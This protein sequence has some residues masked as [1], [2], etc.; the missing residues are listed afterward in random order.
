MRFWKNGL[1]ILTFIFAFG[2]SG[3]SK[4]SK[5]ERH[6]SRAEKYFSENKFKEAIIEYKNVL[7][8]EP[9]DA[10]ARHRLGMAY[11]RVGQLREAFSEFVKAVDSDPENAEA[12]IQLGNLY[13]LS[14]DN[15]KA[16]EQ[17]EKVLSRQPN[18]PA[19]R[20]LMSSVF[21]AE[22]NLSGAVSEAQKAIELDP[23][24]IDSHL[25]LANLCI[26][27]S[28]FCKMISPRPR[29]LSGKRSERMRNPPRPGTRWGSSTAAPV[30]S[31]K[32]KSNLRKSLKL[33]PRMQ[34]PG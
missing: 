19:G 31:K 25:H 23:Q 1:L 10:K 13:L 8:L 22:K 33:P 4:E 15:Q 7:Q 29:M 26:Q 12:R 9:K 21:L 34:M 17:A 20:L 32:P 16:R 14:K 2:L 3:C 18:N 11:L 5:M 30:R 24:K 28:A 27:I 6:W